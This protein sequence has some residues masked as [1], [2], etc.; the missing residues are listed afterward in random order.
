[1]KGSNTS[2]LVII[3][4]ALAGVAAVPGAL[5]AMHEQTSTQSNESDT[6]S[7]DDTN[8]TASNETE[9][10]DNMTAAANDTSVANAMDMSNVTGMDN[11]TTVDQANETEGNETAAEVTEDEDGVSVTV[12]PFAQSPGGSVLVQAEG[13]EPGTNA[14]I[15]VDNELAATTETDGNGTVL[16]ALG[17]PSEP[18]TR[19]TIEVDNETGEETIT[20]DTHAWEGTVKVVVQDEA[21]NRGFA[22]LTVLAP[23]DQPGET[24]ASE[25]NITRET[26]DR[27]LD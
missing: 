21:N 10:E 8:V 12:T 20:K 3:L 27:F 11:E 9:T 22:D 18:V 1:M 23:V 6:M 14:T 5:G 26:L 17:I 24:T 16:Y 7:A 4:S 15:T 25:M 2:Y 13:L 19:M